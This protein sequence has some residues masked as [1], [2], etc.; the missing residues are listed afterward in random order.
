MPRPF[1]YKTKEER[2]AAQQVAQ[3]KWRDTH[4]EQRQAR[5]REL[6]KNLRMEIL[7]HYENKCACCAETNYEFLALDHIDGGGKA[8]RESFRSSNHYYGWIKKQGFPS[9]FRVLCHNC[10][11]ALG[12]YGYCPHQKDSD[13]AFTTS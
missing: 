9:I 4:K 6:F 7:A 2:V 1:K 8:H 10:N 13:I 5:A 12:W 3:K 11:Q